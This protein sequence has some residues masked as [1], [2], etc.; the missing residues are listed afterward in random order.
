MRGRLQAFAPVRLPVVEHYFV[1]RFQLTSNQLEEA[2]AL[3]LVGARG[4]LGR[5]AGFDRVVGIEVICP[6]QYFVDEPRR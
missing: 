6:R 5:P 2:T 4:D 3:A 1:L